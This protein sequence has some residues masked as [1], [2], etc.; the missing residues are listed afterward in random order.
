M[1]GIVVDQKKG[2]VEIQSSFFLHNVL[3]QNS[4]FEY[5]LIVP[6]LFVIRLQSGK[7]FTVKLINEEL[8]KYLFSPFKFHNIATMNFA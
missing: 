6:C 5:I 8:N 4:K 7:N 1:H 2:I 3:N